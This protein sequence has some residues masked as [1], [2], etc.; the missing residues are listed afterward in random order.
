MDRVLQIAFNEVGYLEKKSNNNLDDKLKNAGSNNYTKYWR[1]IAPSMQGQSWCNAFVNWCFNRAYGNKAKS[2][3]CCTA[4]SFYTPTSASYFKK[5]GRWYTKPIKGDIIYFKNSTRIFHI[6]IVYDV[7]SNY[8]YTVEGNTSGGSSVVANGGGV[9][10]KKYL[11]NNSRIAGYGRPI[12]SDTK[13]TTTNTPTLS[14]GSTDKALNGNYVESW[15]RYLSLLGY[16]CNITGIFDNS[17]KNAVIEYQKSK[18]LV[19]DGIVGPKTWATI[20]G[21][22]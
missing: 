7:D 10:K 9:F 13:S 3:L 17:T 21:G 19:A 1:D 11:L 14:L 8:V 20:L 2:M 18:N 15:Q 6:G 5:A 12:Y 16:K 22:K 4:W